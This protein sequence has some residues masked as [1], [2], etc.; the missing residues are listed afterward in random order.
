MISL[1]LTLFGSPQI[2]LNDRLVQLKNR[3]AV[4]LLAYLVLS[5]LPQSREK[6]VSV[7]WPEF[8]SDRAFANLR[9]T[10]HVIK[11]HLT[12]DWL[13]IRR[14]EVEVKDTSLFWADVLEFQ[15]HCD[16]VN[17]HDSGLSTTCAEC[18]PLLLTAIE[19]YQDDFLRGFTLPD[20]PIFDEWQAFHI[21][22]YRENLSESLHRVVRY[23]TRHHQLLPAIEY[24]RRWIAFFPWSETAH[25]ELMRLYGLNH[26]CP[27]A[28]RQYQ[29][30]A[31][32]LQKEFG[33]EP[34]Q[35][36]QELY[37][38]IFHGNLTSY[39]NYRD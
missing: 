35:Q 24:A 4:A 32:M 36:T 39:C 29:E 16:H 12:D 3:K 34:E 28:L 22:L 31:R 33:V 6:L 9:E 19:L 20:S 21:D 10:L 38:A 13:D 11:V 27:D 2:H 5:Q 23:Y 15:Q 30:C 25:R 14:Q 18:L 26:Q 7:F 37:E 8:S 17:R 1:R